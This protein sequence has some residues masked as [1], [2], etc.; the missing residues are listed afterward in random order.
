MSCSAAPVFEGD[1]TQW[2]GEQ[3]LFM[4]LIEQAFDLQFGFWLLIFLLQQAFARRLHTFGDDLIIA[5][6]LVTA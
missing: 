6:R 5:A 2:A 3:R 4:L 1:R